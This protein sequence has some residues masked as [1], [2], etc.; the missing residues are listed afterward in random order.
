MKKKYVLFLAIVL[1]SIITLYKSILKEKDNI[2]LRNNELFKKFSIDNIKLTNECNTLKLSLEE[3]K[4]IIIKI[5]SELEEKIHLL[6]LENLSKSDEIS[7]FLKHLLK[8]I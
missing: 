1:I 4:N 7:K 3:N 6:N 8:K 5:N 2:I